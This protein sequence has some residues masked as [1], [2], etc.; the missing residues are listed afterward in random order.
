LEDCYAKLVTPPI[1]KNVLLHYFNLFG[2]PFALT[3][4]NTLADLPTPL[5]LH[6]SKA[7]D[8]H[9]KLLAKLLARKLVTTYTDQSY[10]SKIDDDAIYKAKLK[11]DIAIGKK[12]HPNLETGEV[13]FKCPNC[14]GT[15]LQIGYDTITYRY[16]E[17][18]NYDALDQSLDIEDDFTSD[19]EVTGWD[20]HHYRCHTCD[21][22]WYS[23][24]AMLR[25]NAFVNVTE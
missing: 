5:C 13:N 9:V 10:S 15:L 22:R 3:A 8:A 1:Q 11:I 2:D 6:N 12:V 19:P 14:G 24:D 17:T 21:K 18:I 7:N 25:D 16:A 23:E 20:V 4:V